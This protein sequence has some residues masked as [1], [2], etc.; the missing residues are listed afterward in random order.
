[1][2]KL[3]SFASFATVTLALLPVIAMLLNA[4]VLTVANGL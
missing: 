1:M 3:S 4:Q 2:T